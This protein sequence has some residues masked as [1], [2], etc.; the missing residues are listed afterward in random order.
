MLNILPAAVKQ[1]AP[2]GLAE[3]VGKQQPPAPLP[4]QPPRWKC[5]G[6]SH[7]KALRKRIRAQKEETTKRCENFN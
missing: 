3:G 5:L 2:K 7:F 4:L 6:T 1:G